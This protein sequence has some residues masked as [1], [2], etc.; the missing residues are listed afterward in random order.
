[1]RRNTK[2]KE[3]IGLHP[4]LGIQVDKKKSFLGVTIQGKEELRSKRMLRGLWKTS[5]RWL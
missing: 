4:V 3:N 1:M 2:R 5:G